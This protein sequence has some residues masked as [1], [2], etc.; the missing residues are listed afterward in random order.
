MLVSACGAEEPKEP[1]LGSARSAI[2]QGSADPTVSGVVA[3]LTI[4]RGTLCTG[5][6]AS[7]RVVLT[8]RH[9]VAPI[10][11]GEPLDCA[12]S[13]FGAPSSPDSVYVVT[14][15]GTAI[16]DR[17]HGVMRVIVPD[18]PSFCGADVA[19]LVLPEPLD[20]A[21]AKPIPLRTDIDVEPSEL[22]AAV[23][24]GRDGTLAPSGT[25]RRRE[26]LRVSCVGR[27]CRSSQ[28]T[29]QEWWGEGAVCEGDSGGPAI[30]DEGRVIGIASRKREGCTATVYLDLARSADFI[31]S[32][33][34]EARRMPLR[35]DTAGCSTGGAATGTPLGLVLAFLLLRRRIAVRTP[36]A[37][38]SQ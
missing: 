18:D 27:A 24:F 5:V 3:V 19:A 11:N 33:L 13:T 30:D 28:L 26:D 32:A 21:E 23:G 10:K 4:D 36:A 2:S 35:H 6:L 8:A 25:R 34:G 7:P 29:D 38:R 14:A 20:E 17:R 16:P 1:S 12:K 31:A 9:C 22:F 15:A 37:A